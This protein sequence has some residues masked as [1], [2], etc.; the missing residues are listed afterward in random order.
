[1]PPTDGARTVSNVRRV[2]VLAA[3]AIAAFVAVLVLLNV[4]YAVGARLT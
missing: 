2:L 1:M 3:V 4:L